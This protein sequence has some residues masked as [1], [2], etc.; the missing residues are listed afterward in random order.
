MQTIAVH[1]VIDRVSE[2]VCV[3]VTVRGTYCTG[4]VRVSSI[5]VVWPLIWWERSHVN[6]SV[7]SVMTGGGGCQSWCCNFDAI[8]FGD[9]KTEPGYIYI[10][11]C[12]CVCVC[13]YVCVC[14]CVWISSCHR[15][16]SHWAVK[17]RVSITFSVWSYTL[18]SSPLVFCSVWQG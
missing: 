16:E 17:N 6:A 9:A 7:G 1:K 2:C 13:V 12:L 11:V 10:Y 5:E 18:K 4:Y 15:T 8:V 3:C 14:V